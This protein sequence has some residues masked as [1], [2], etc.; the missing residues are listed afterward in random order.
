VNR[1]LG[2]EH[3]EDHVF[4]MPTRRTSEWDAA[5]LI[6][7]GYSEVTVLHTTETVFECLSLK[8]AFAFFAI[9]SS[10]R[11]PF[12]DGARS[13]ETRPAARRRDL[14]C[15]FAACAA[16]AEL[17]PILNFVSKLSSAHTPDGC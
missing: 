15:G 1:R 10:T 2:I 13:S 5:Q 14:S 9:L 12:H 11:M 7:G 6:R 3:D 4:G 8:G 16:P 17:F